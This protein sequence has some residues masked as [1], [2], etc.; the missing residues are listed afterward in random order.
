MKKRKLITTK[1]AAKIFGITTDTIRKYKDRELIEPSEKSGKKDLWDKDY[2]VRMRHIIQS[3]KGQGKELKQIAKDIELI[4][5]EQNLSGDT[6]VK[7]ILIIED[8]KGL[9]DIY[10]KFIEES[11][12]DK[13]LRIYQVEDGLTGIEYGIRIKPHVIILDL[14]LPEKSGMDVHKELK[15]HP[16]T[17]NTKFIIVSGNIKYK[18]KDAV[19]LMKP[20]T[21]DDF[22]EKANSLIET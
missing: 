8:D 1:E 19:F 9:G 20:F 14:A 2:I 11:F 3:G 6:D 16:S 12:P 15:D 4:K 5:G 17:C 7:R 22:L 10:K 21:L 18:A 13:S